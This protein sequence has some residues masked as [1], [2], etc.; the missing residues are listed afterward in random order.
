MRPGHFFPL[1]PA[2]GRASLPCTQLRCFAAGSGMATGLANKVRNG[3][4][5]CALSLIKLNVLLTY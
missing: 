5:R 3:K 2:A 4:T 1:L